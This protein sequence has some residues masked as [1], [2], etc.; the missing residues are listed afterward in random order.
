MANNPGDEGSE[1]SPGDFTLSARN[2][3]RVTA[4]VAIGVS[5]LSALIL[6]MVLYFVLI[7]HSEKN[8]LEAIASLT[9]S[10]QQLAFAM[11]VA[12]ALILILAGIITWL[13]TLYFSHR[14]AGPIYRFTKNLE[15]EIE[16]GPVSTI[17]IRKEDSLQALSTKLE[18]AAEGLSRYYD[19]QKEIVDQIYRLVDGEY[20]VDGK[21]FSKRIDQL[22]KTVSSQQ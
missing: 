13:V 8:Y 21:E 20:E 7:D 5:L 6:F 22:Q 16:K 17:A 2:R 19:S 4:K 15:L 1:D 10:Q 9:R 11:F 18:T 3:L 14:I 12:G